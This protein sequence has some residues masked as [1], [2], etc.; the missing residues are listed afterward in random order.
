MSF[1]KPTSIPAL[2]PLKET[3][4]YPLE[5]SF[6]GRD[7]TRT[8]VRDVS[9]KKLVVFFFMQRKTEKVRILLFF[10]RRIYPF[11]EG[12]AEHVVSFWEANL[13]CSAKKKYEHTSR[14]TKIFDF[15]TQKS[16]IKGH[17]KKPMRCEG[18]LKK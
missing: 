13:L 16:S 7:T 5:V 10:L 15:N 11:F 8:L 18:C 3:S 1:Q 14:D 17:K 6:L 9:Q 4:T 2:Y 12:C